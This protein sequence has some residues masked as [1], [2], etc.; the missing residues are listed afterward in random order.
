MRHVYSCVAFALACSAVSVTCGADSPQVGPYSDLAQ[1]EIRGAESY[2]PEEIRTAL[3]HDF[4]TLAA[5]HPL[6]PLIDLPGVIRERVLA[7]Y[8]SDGFADARVEVKIDIDL[9]RIVVSIDEGRRYTQGGIR[10]ENAEKIDAAQLTRRLSERYAPPEAVKPVFAGTASD[11]IVGWEDRDGKRVKWT[12]PIWRP[13]E[14]ARH[15]AAAHAIYTRELRRALEDL[16]FRHAEFEVELVADPARKRSDLV[17]RLVDEGSPAIVRRIKFTGNQRDSDETL[18][19]HLD[20]TPGMLF[21]RQREARLNYDVWHSG[22]FLSVECDLLEIPN[23]QE[24]ELLVRLTESPHAPP[25]RAAPTRAQQ[26]ILKMARWLADNRNWEEDAVVNIKE[27]EGTFEAILSPQEGLILRMQ[28][29]DGSSAPLTFMAL[30]S[31]L[32]CYPAAS[33]SHYQAQFDDRIIALTQHHDVA[34]EPKSPEKIFSFTTGIGLHSR[35]EGDTSPPFQ[36][37]L[38]ITPAACVA[39]A[40]AERMTHRWEGGVL[41]VESAQARFEIDAETGKLLRYESESAETGGTMTINFV[42]G[43]FA[44][45]QREFQRSQTGSHNAYDP[46]RP[47]RSSALFFLSDAFI[48]ELTAQHRSLYKVELLTPAQHEARRAFAALVALG[49]LDPVDAWIVSDAIKD[50]DEDRFTIPSATGAKGGSW[51]QA[52]AKGA[53]AGAD[54]IAPRDTWIWTVIRETGFLVAGQ[55]EHTGTALNQLMQDEEAGPLAYLTVA[56]LLNQ[57]KNRAAPQVAGRGK[58]RLAKQAFLDDCQP[59]LDDQHLIG[60]SILR[61]SENIRL[62]EFDELEE[63]VNQLPPVW[64]PVFSAYAAELRSD[65]VRPIRE[66]AAAGL[67]AAWEAGLEKEIDRLLGEIAGW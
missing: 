62:L 56:S 15:D 22:R 7:G 33:P 44:H 28:S 27:G 51:M 6:A 45:A 13:G 43:A 8:R 52:V 20:L 47:L 38:Q 4:L 65:T 41:I 55:N 50:K 58:L 3:S 42:A 59:L 49:A 19:K 23:E 14:A 48:Q 16:G 36:A 1:L 53:V 67:E 5:A 10:I 18:V 57:L 54:I 11:E 9:L 39:M 24:H 32:A 61:A 40:H 46:T 60:K 25:L 31:G 2:S 37:E 66:G 34:L 30:R 21:H 35:G 63:V 12:K 64:Q 26:T 17:I 29:A